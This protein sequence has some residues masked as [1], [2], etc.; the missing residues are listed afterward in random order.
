M[1]INLQ[2]FWI[3]RFKNAKDCI[4]LLLNHF[5]KINISIW[6]KTQSFLN[7]NLGEGYIILKELIIQNGEKTKFDEKISFYGRIFGNV[8]GLKNL[9]KK[10][11]KNFNIN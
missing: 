5:E 6:P 8:T 11:N 1:Y 10:N 2:T 7:K 4:L 9:K 3:K